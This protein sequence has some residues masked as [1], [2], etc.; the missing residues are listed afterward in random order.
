MHC[1]ANVGK[2]GDVSLFFGLSGTGKTTLSADPERALIGDDEHGWDDDGVFNFEGG[3]YAKTI[4]L[5]EKTEPD[6]YRAIH[7]D[8]LLENVKIKDGDNTPDY[9][10]TSK[11][12]N[13]RV[14]YPIFHIPNY[15][16]S[17]VVQCSMPYR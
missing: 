12:E 10:D 5:T 1:S 2:K 4:S 9:F 17:S 7:T 16:S 6:I 13:G 3:C 8:A 14:S 11:T 15:V